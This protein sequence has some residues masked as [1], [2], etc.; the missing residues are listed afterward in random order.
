MTTFE[1]FSPEGRPAPKVRVT[2]R[3]RVASSLVEAKVAEVWDY[4][5]RGDEVF[6]ALRDSLG[7]SRPGIGFVGYDNFGDIH[8]TEANALVEA[9]PGRLDATGADVAVVGV[10]A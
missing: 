10:G 3:R 4:R 1:V 5:F 8:G 6:S 2:D 7:R 9:L